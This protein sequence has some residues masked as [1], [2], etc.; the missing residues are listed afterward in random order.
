MARE[1]SA[2]AGDGPGLRDGLPVHLEERCLAEGGDAG[3]HPGGAVRDYL[4]LK[5]NLQFQYKDVMNDV[6]NRDVQILSLL[7][8]VVGYQLTLQCF[9][10]FNNVH[11][12][13]H[14]RT[15]DFP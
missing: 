4:V 2:V 15:D 9:P 13:K 8:F 10:L 14:C 11:K 7:N 3:R 12:P 6:M 5:F 1:L